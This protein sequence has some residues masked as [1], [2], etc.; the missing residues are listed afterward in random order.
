MPDVFTF[1]E[2]SPESGS[3]ISLHLLMRKLR[4]RGH[5]DIHNRAGI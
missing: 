1:I 4:L 5:I 2:S 3:M